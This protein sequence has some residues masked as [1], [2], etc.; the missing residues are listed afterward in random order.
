MREQIKE[1]IERYVDVETKS[2][3]VDVEEMVSDIMKVLEP[4]EVFSDTTE[5]LG[6]IDSCLEKKVLILP[7]R[8]VLKEA[9]DKILYLE[10]RLYLTP[11]DSKVSVEKDDS[12]DTVEIVET[13]SKLVKERIFTDNLSELIQQAANRL[14]DLD[15]ENEQLKI[16]INDSEHGLD[17]I[18]SERIYKVF[19][20]TPW[21][22]SVIFYIGGEDGRLTVTRKV[23]PD[24]DL[25]KRERDLEIFR[26][27]KEE[28]FKV[29]LISKKEEEV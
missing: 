14:V 8:D 11:R 20:I 12:T 22:K 9:K 24:P 3:V 5:L 2:D 29:V 23:T 17:V 21:N 7:L 25:S 18:G 27:L 10:A 28:G 4:S 6:K 13:L 15:H 26:A 1:V 16:K 19:K